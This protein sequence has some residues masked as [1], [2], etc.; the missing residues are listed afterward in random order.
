VGVSFKRFL[1]S[2][3]CLK[4]QMNILFDIAQAMVATRTVKT[5]AVSDIGRQRRLNILFGSA[6][7]AQ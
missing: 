2:K 7:S 5:V 1:F 6:A 3:K 4:Q